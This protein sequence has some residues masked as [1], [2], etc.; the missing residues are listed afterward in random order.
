MSLSVAGEAD[1]STPQ[2]LLKAYEQRINRHDF[3]LL[4]GLIAADAVFWFS[5]GTH[6]GLSPIRAA[7]EATWGL[8]Q[9][10]AYWLDEVTWVA[11]GDSAAACLY[12]F[13]WRADQNG[14]T[15]SGS[16][17]GTTVCRHGSAGWQI[18]HEHLS[19]QP[20]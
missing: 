2:G 8:L 18:V 10:E 7:F 3:D 9:D 1:L 12:R 5:D 11:M 4:E 15:I 20:G 14:R 16:G 17:R 6:H 13:N 19:R